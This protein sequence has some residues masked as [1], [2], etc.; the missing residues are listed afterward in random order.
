MAVWARAHLRLL[1]VVAAGLVVVIALV[2]VV[3]LSAG[4]GGG[5]KVAPGSLV[6]TGPLTTGYRLTGTVRQRTPSSLT[7][8][9]TQI[10][11]SGAEARNVVLRPGARVEF[12]R[13]VDGPVML[14]RNGRLVSGADKLHVGDAVTLVGEFTAVTGPGRPH[15]GYA[16]LAVEASSG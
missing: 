12:D 7:L 2:I 5:T 14:A 8:S 4:G 11:A 1:A 3:A 6:G 15:Q 13:P 16:Y 9:I 10:E